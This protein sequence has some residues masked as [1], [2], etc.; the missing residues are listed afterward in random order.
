MA[1]DKKIAFNRFLPL[2]LVDRI[3]NRRMNHEFEL[4]A[5]QPF[6]CARAPELSRLNER[7]STAQKSSSTANDARPLPPAPVNMRM[8]FCRSI[9]MKI[10]LSYNTNLK[11]FNKHL[12]IMCLCIFLIGCLKEGID[13][14]AKNVSKLYNC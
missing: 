2:Y 1:K 14:V 3:T 4:E 8:W 11:G 13:I 10:K 5:D 6:P 7:T 9:K 12:K